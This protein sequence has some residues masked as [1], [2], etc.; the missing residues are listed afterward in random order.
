MYEVFNLIANILSNIK[1]IQ[2][3]LL[4]I[5]HKMIWL[6]GQKHRPIKNTENSQI[7]KDSPFRN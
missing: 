6:D 5:A 2:E 4:V 7:L 3:Y 1:I